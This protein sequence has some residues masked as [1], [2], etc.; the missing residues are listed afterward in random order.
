MWG[1]EQASAAT[2]LT[3]DWLYF[4]SGLEIFLCGFLWRCFFSLR[5]TEAFVRHAPPLCLQSS[6]SILHWVVLSY[7]LKLS[8]SKTIPSTLLTPSH[9]SLPLLSFLLR[10]C[11]SPVSLRWPSTSDSLGP[12]SNQLS[13]SVSPQEGLSQLLAIVPLTVKWSRLVLY[14]TETLPNAFS[15]YPQLPVVL[16][17]LEITYGGISPTSL[18]EHHNGYRGETLNKHSGLVWFRPTS[19]YS[20]PLHSFLCITWKFWQTRL[21]AG[22][23]MI[24]QVFPPL[25]LCPSCF[26][27]E[28]HSSRSFKKYFIYQLFRAPSP[29]P[30]TPTQ[31][32]SPFQRSESFSSHLCVL[33]LT[34][35][36]VTCLLL[37]WLYDFVLPW[38]T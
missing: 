11:S 15:V 32:L 7:A 2:P 21:L 27:H 6:N 12:I 26:L 3:R 24:P 8:V 31:N 10:N 22:P 28:Q 16:S 36:L 35:I 18:Q 1:S 38:G 9:K 14:L 29:V 37:F 23:V 34:G 13:S 25:G 19:H 4:L 30:P 5:A 33:I 20:P 17:Y